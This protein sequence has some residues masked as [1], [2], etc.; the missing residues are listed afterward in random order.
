MKLKDKE[1]LNF[2]NN[3]ILGYYECMYDI[4]NGLSKTR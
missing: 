4:I 3:I 2:K 1:G